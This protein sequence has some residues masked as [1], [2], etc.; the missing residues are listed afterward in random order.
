MGN[1]TWRFIMWKVVSKEA[2]AGGSFD[3][4][5]DSGWSIP[6]STVIFCPDAKVS[7]EE[8]CRL[9]LGSLSASE[10]NYS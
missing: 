10:I 2:T 7:R 1:F 9:P 8:T 3:F 4:S 5:L 6:V